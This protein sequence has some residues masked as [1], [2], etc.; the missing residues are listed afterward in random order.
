MDFFLNDCGIESHD[1]DE[2]T[3]VRYCF[4]RQVKDLSVDVHS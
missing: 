3:V 4:K 1:H 2:T